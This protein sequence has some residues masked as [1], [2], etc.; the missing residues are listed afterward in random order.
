MKT[1]SS[2]P[3]LPLV[4]GLLCTAF[5]SEPAQGGLERWTRIGPPGGVIDH[6]AVA[7]SAPR[8]VYALHGF[9]VLRSTDGGARFQSVSGPFGD[10]FAKTL[11]V[12]PARARTVL[13]FTES[14]HGYGLFRTSDGGERW[15]LLE[16]P[17]TFLT[18]LSFAPTSADRVYADDGLDVFRSLDVGE[19]WQ[20]RSAGLPARR[21]LLDFDIDRRDASRVWTLVED[22]AR[23]R[24]FHSTDGGGRWVERH[25]GLPADIR[26]LAT[27]PALQGA[28]YAYTTNTIFHTRDAG[29]CWRQ[30]STAAASALLALEGLEVSPGDPRT[31]YAARARQTPETAFYSDV[32][33]KPE[34]ARTSWVR[35]KDQ[36][37]LPFF[38]D[39]W[40]GDRTAGPLPTVCRHARGRGR[41][42]ELDLPELI[43]HRHRPRGR[44]EALS[45]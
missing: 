44:R 35:L 14:A 15:E 11:A 41:R 43:F 34:S 21:V 37:P 7:P 31:L 18:R 23:R 32:F 19:T 45:L 17:P 26:G 16:L 3:L 9:E 8:H 24:V 40:A 13:V 5:L 4:G 22:G 27:D 28:A 42:S 1:N 39:Q 20:V 36:R 33:V 2:T 30:V 38:A 29:R 6:V 12:S 25:R 10:R